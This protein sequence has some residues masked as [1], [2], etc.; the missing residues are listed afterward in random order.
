[1]PSSLIWEVRKVFLDIKR[2]VGN[3]LK[4]FSLAVKEVFICTRFFSVCCCFQYLLKIHLYISILSYLTLICLRLCLGIGPS[5]LAYFG[6]CSHFL[7]AFQ[8]MLVIVFRLTM[9]LLLFSLMFLL[10]YDTRRTTSIH[11]PSTVVTLSDFWF[12]VSIFNFFDLFFKS[13]NVPVLF[14]NSSLGFSIAD[15]SVSL[16]LCYNLMYRLLPPRLSS[17]FLFLTPLPYFRLARLPLP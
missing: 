13:F 3:V 1:M 14:I 16:S 9:P 5:S 11:M 10:S 17:V 6:G 12:L 4:V 2:W 7:N 15:F 8:Q